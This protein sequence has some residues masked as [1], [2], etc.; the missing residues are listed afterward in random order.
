MTF[1]TRLE[2]FYKHR[3]LHFL[4]VHLGKRPL[5]PDSVD[6]SR[7]MRIIVIRQHD[8]L[9]DMLL[10]TP[11]FHALRSHFPRA[12]ITV[13]IRSYTQEILEHH[14]CIDEILTLEENF[15]QWTNKKAVRFW[16]GLR[17][18]Y[19]LAVVLNTV[20]HSLS[21][22]TLA[23]LSRAQYVLG[24]DHL[25]FKGCERNFFYN[26]LAPYGSDVKHQSERNL[27]I[28]RYIGVD[29]PDLHE[30]IELT[31]DEVI[32]ASDYLSRFDIIKGDCVVGVHPGAGKVENR[33]SLEK[34][35][36]VG[37]ELQRST[38]FR[39]IIFQGLGEDNLVEEL[40]A[41]MKT[42]CYIIPVLRLRR[43]AAVL[44][45]LNLFLC[46]DTGV[47]HLAASVGTPLVT[48]FGPT[49]SVCWKPWGTNFVAVQGKNGSI[50]SV[51]PDEVFRTC[52]KL[53]KNKSVQ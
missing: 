23:S 3:L 11:V 46:N 19:D 48:V 21:S 10:S 33:W 32:W 7:I 18:H 52:R 30:K 49:D 50:Q 20:S 41:A 45:R 26:L 31:Q 8:Q 14:P 39:I 22:D 16:S 15:R 24:S 40:K 5:N 13:I 28:V 37:D 25:L 35:A 36:W 34:F 47:M 2:Q 42:K 53:L 12:H 44:S 4:E 38:G 27:D 9:G 29:T 6:K 51:E 43:L 1:W 17:K